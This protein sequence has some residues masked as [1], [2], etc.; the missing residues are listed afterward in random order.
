MPISVTNIGTASDHSTTTSSLNITVPV[1]GVPTGAL[2][3]C[4]AATTVAAGTG[5]AGA[6]TDT[7][8]INT[9]A[10]AWSAGNSVGF[11]GVGANGYIILGYSFNSS[12]LTSANAV[13][14]NTSTASHSDGF[15]AFYA[16]G[17]QTSSDPRDT[18]FQNTATGSSAA[19]SVAASAV[20]AAA[21]SLVIGI[22]GINAPSSDTFTQDSTNAAYANFPIRVG[23][24]AGS[25]LSNA[26]IAGGEIVSSAQLTYAPALGTSRTWAAAITAFKPASTGVG[27]ISGTGMIVGAE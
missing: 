5:I 19:P 23:S 27:D 3:V 11:N 13:T 4:C 1:G 16:T 18:A 21:G 9:Y 8:G 7:A 2:I 10:T 20:P 17:I 12:A 25:T 15:S 24:S 22:V 26:T 6:F 14:F